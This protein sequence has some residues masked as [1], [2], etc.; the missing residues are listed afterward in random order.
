L[1]GSALCF[2]ISWGLRSAAAA[3][4]MVPQMLL[5]QEVVPP[6]ATQEPAE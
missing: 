1:P 6:Q 5:W 2:R 3:A 4:E